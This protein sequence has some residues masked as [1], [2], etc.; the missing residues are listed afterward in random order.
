MPRSTRTH[1]PSTARSARS[2]LIV[3]IASFVLPSLLLLGAGFRLFTSTGRDDAHI[4]YWAA[5]ALSEFGQIVNYNGERVEQSS[6]LLHVL[7]I[8][9][10]RSITHADAVTIGKLTSIAAAV[11]TLILLCVVLRRIA[12]PLMALLGSTLAATSAYFMYWSFGGLET[13]LVSFTGAWFVLAIASYVSQPRRRAV[14]HVAVATFAFGLVRPES[15]L[16]AIAVAVAGAMGSLALSP[17]RDTRTWMRRWF[18]PV[19]IAVL[20]CACIVSWRLMYFGSTF[21]QP[22][23]AKYVGFSIGSFVRGID[24]V[25]DAVFGSGGRIAFALLTAATACAWLAIGELRARRFAPLL[26][27]LLLFV[28]GYLAFAVASGGDWMEGG[29]FLVFVIPFAIGLIPFA[30]QSAIRDERSLT[31]VLSTLTATL[32]LAQAH[33]LVSFARAESVGTWRWRELRV[34]DDVDLDG[35]SWFERANRVNM[36]DAV[37]IHELKGLIPRI[38]EKY[39]DDTVVLMTGQ[40]GMVPFHIA[41][42]FF[43]HVRFID[44]RGLCDRMLT[45]CAAADDVPRD[46]RG[47]RMEYLDYFALRD[48]LEDECALPRPDIVFDLRGGNTQIVSERGYSTV[49][50]QY[51]EIE[52]IGGAGAE[53]EASA[54]VSV[55]AELWVDL[56]E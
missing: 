23:S 18:P 55:R 8:A 50:R 21:P 19:V 28:G 56:H 48:R 33:A 9:A 46:T 45:A 31:L 24:Y 38:K 3:S 11:G 4:T 54:F 34:A 6:S 35:Y 47:V 26:G 14:A 37:V 2:T 12:D 42:R 15:P 44:R 32:L 36:R 13:T 52:D 1:P 27:L 22:V 41:Q 39:P 25:R 29:R 40:M 16:V 20:A 5:Y 17:S 7:L 43:G 10:I 30:V 53:V 51:G 49:A